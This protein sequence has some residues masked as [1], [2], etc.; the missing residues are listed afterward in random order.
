LKGHEGRLCRKSAS[1]A[2]VYAQQ[3]YIK[4]SKGI[5]IQPASSNNLL[6]ATI[7]T[8]SST[9]PH[10]IEFAGGEVGRGKKLKKILENCF[11]FFIPVFKLTLCE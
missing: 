1:K 2:L 10:G 3:N 11:N 7:C 4:A 9:S 6:S 5:A 8:F